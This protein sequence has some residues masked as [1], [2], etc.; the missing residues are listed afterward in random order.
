MHFAEAIATGSVRPDQ[1][2]T[3]F[4]ALE[5]VDVGFLAGTWRGREF[6]SGHPMDGSLE[7]SGWYG[8]RFTDSESVDPLLFH[9]AARSGYFVADPIGVAQA[10]AQGVRDLSAIRKAI[11][12]PAPAARLRRVE[13][14]G[15]LSAAMVYDRL[16]VIDHFRR[17]DEV[18]LLGAMDRRGDPG[19]YF[20]VLDREG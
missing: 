20:F 7:C 4:D 14:R 17:V 2:F 18:T 12:A 13:Y 8:K 15:V 19:T 6:P 5:P 10:L 16:P 11:E 9:D 3:L 1:A